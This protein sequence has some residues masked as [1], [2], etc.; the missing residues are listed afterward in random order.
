MRRILVP[1][2][3]LSQLEQEVLALCVWQELA[4]RDVA[5]ALDVPE[6]TVRTRLHR[7]RNHLRSA[8][9]T[10]SIPKGVESA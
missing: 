10:V 3:R 1:V 4:P 2:A 6:A 8:A 5:R 9:E 7:A